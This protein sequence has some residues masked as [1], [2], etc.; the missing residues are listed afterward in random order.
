[1]TG[2]VLSVTAPLVLSVTEDSSYQ[3]P[4]HGLS[5]CGSYQIQSLNYA[6]IESFRFLLT[7]H[8]IVED[9]GAVP[10]RIH[11]GTGKNC[12]SFIVTGSAK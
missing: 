11:A 7:Q 8:C 1:M 5:H 6:N 2:L 3:E 9:L 12:I 4:K 10:A